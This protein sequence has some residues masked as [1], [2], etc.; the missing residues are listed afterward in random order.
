MDL[1]KKIVPLKLI[2]VLSIKG[3]CEIKAEGNLVIDAVYD[4]WTLEWLILPCLS[5]NTDMYYETLL[6]LFKKYGNLAMF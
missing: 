6:I 5:R 4:N 3:K 1:W 2:K